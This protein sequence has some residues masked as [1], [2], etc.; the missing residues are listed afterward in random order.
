MNRSLRYYGGFEY[1]D[2]E[3]IRTYGDYVI[4]SAETERVQ[5]VIDSLSEETENA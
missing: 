5:D 2:D 3:Y 4:Y 1:V